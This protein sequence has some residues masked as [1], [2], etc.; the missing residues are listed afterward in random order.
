[1]EIEGLSAYSRN[2]PL[3]SCRG[4]LNLFDALVIFLTIYLN[5]IPLSTASSP[6]SCMSFEVSNKICKDSLFKPA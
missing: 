1:M 6:T 4:N 3:N 5:I 2:S